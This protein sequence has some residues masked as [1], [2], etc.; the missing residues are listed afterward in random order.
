MKF[1]D[2]D[3]HE[4]VELYKKSKLRSNPLIPFKELKDLIVYGISGSGKY[5]S[6]LYYLSTFS[7]SCLKYD[8]KI[9]INV[10][11][12]AIYYIRISDIH[13]EIDMEQLGCNAKQIW[14]E[15]YSHIIHIIQQYKYYQV[16]MCKNFHKINPDL[17]KVFYSYIQDARDYQVKFILITDHISFIPNNIYKYFNIISTPKLSSTQ[18]IK[19]IGNKTT[20]KIGLENL[21][22]Y[23]S[24]FPLV[25][26]HNKL[27][28][29]LYDY[30]DQYPDISYKVVR[31][32]LYDFLIYDIDVSL[33]LWK[34]IR[35]YITLN[36]VIDINC[37]IYINEF[38]QLYNNN[39]R[40]IYHLEKIIY[41]IVD[42]I[43]GVKKSM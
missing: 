3:L 38:F 2:G 22:A 11:K 17:L 21:K 39:Y 30:L 23:K 10:G 12:D 16:I 41:Y 34:L 31:D 14:H 25:P 32:Y 40:P 9:T 7:N 15:I 35:K 1:H 24:G 43:H 33:L 26:Y 28:D 27:C 19:K 36:I 42:D 18:C 5:S 4:Y 20:T 29:T 37:I 8:K 13:Y 6:V